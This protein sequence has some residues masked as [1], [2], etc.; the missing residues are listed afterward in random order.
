[1]KIGIYKDGKKWKARW[2]GQFDP[3]TGNQKRYS[4][5]FDRKK[6]AERFKKQREGE[7]DGGMSLDPSTKGLKEYAENWLHNKTVNKGLRVATVILYKES[8]YRLYAYF[9]E[10][11]LLQRITRSAGQDFLASL[12]P[13]NSEGTLSGWTRNR[14]LQNCKTLFSDA[15]DNGVIS[16][17]PFSKIEK[18]TATTSE[19]YH[20]KPDEYQRLIEVTDKLTDKVLYALCYTAGLRLGEALSIRWTDTDFDKGMV[21]IANQPAT[22]ETPPFEVK[23]KDARAI[24]LPQHTLSLLLQLQSSAPERVPYILLDEQRYEKIVSKWDA[25]RKAGRTWQNNNF[26]NNVLR[27]FKLRCKRAGIKPIGKLTIH[28]LR[29]CC[30]QN[31]ADNLPMNVVAHLA[32]HSDTST[33][34]KF[35]STVDEHH[36]KAAARVT[37]ELLSDPKNT[38]SGDSESNQDVEQPEQE[39][40]SLQSKDLI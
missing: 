2:Y 17:N 3:T 33:T 16:L 10:D 35:Y 11:C 18:A 28:V 12:K 6:D 20:L 13:L 27:N 21:R 7:V 22:D 36:L 26:A 30:I 1:M 19:W 38:F 24:P 40:K 8:L 39:C 34:V 25:V 32:G 9:G 31:W 5:T 14:V 23:D 37:D 29:K 4:K 15:V